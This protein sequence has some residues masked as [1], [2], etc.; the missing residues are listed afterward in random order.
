MK[1]RMW[2]V[3]PDHKLFEVWFKDPDREWTKEDFD[4]EVRKHRELFSGYE[5]ISIAI[6]N[7]IGEKEI[8]ILWG[9]ILKNTYLRAQLK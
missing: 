7:E 6:I 2:I 1:M 8:L 4:N 9:N 5:T 3:L